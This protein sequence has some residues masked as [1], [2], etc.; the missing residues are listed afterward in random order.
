MSEDERLTISG[1]WLPAGGARQRRDWAGIFAEPKGPGG[2]PPLGHV[3]RHGD[4]AAW[5]PREL[6]LAGV[7]GAG[8]P[9][10]G[11]GA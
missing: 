2:V 9:A 5:F 6:R 3:M 10:S 4:T 7:S 8:P 11:R 1:C